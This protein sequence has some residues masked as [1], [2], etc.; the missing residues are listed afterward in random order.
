MKCL[1]CKGN[2]RNHTITFIVKVPTGTDAC[3]FGPLDGGV[4]IHTGGWEEANLETPRS[5]TPS[6]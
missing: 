3:C 5:E 1:K 2:V 4:N 6:C